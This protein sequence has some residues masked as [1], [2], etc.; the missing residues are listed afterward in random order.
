MAN[1][2]VWLKRRYVKTGQIVAR[3][4]TL[5]SMATPLPIGDAWDV[6]VENLP[7]KKM[8]PFVEKL[9]HVLSPNLR[10]ENHL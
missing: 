10:Q 7:V 9:N 6:R 8:R 5:L 4:L 3:G 1:T 2:I